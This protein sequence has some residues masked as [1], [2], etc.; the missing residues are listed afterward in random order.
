MQLMTCVNHAVSKDADGDHWPPIRYTLC[1]YCFRHDSV[2]CAS[3]SNRRYV[4]TGFINITRRVSLKGE[5]SATT[6]LRFPES[7]ADLYGDAGHN[8]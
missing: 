3:P 6:T 2:L 1:S 8:K 4:I 5:G 7:L